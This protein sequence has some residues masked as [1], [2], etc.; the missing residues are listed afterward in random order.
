[1]QVDLGNKQILDN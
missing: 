1:M